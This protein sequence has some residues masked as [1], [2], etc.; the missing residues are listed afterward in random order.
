[1]LCRPGLIDQSVL[2]VKEFVN[3]DFACVPQLTV[4]SAIGHLPN[5]DDGSMIC[6]ADLQHI[7]RRLVPRDQIIVDA[8]PP[9]KDSRSIV[10]ARHRDGQV[11]FSL[12][13]VLMVIFA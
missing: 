7:A 6:Y 9:E 11:S 10:R 1:M 3:F 2:R 8:I 12:A 4:Q 5:I 13:S